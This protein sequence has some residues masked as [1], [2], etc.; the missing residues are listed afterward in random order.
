LIESIERTRAAVDSRIDRGAVV[1]TADRT[2][3]GARRL[4]FALVIGALLVVAGGLLACRNDLLTHRAIDAARLENDRLRARQEALLERL[5][6]LV[7]QLEAL[8][9][10]TVPG[11]V[12]VGG[13]EG[14]G[15]ARGGEVVERL[16]EVKAET[17]VTK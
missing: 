11:H 8:G 13:E 6:D 12:E 3:S 9:A 5:S 15:K 16:E 17:E 1:E 4:V 14:L 2:W 7:G 10:E